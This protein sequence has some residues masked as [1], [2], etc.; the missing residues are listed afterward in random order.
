MPPW[1]AATGELEAVPDADEPF[2]PPPFNPNPTPFI[3]NQ[4]SAGDTDYPADG[5]NLDAITTDPEGLDLPAAHYSDP[6]DQDAKEQDQPGDAPVPSTPRSLSSNEAPT[7]PANA[8]TPF[9]RTGATAHQ[10][11][12]HPNAFHPADTDTTRAHFTKPGETEPADTDPDI[13]RQHIPQAAASTQADPPGPGTVPGNTDHTHASHAN[14]D[15]ADANRSD[16]NHSDVNATRP[17]LPRPDVTQGDATHSDTAATHEGDESSPTAAHPTQGSSGPVGN[18]SKPAQAGTE[19][20]EGGAQQ[21]DDT[22]DQPTAAHPRPATLPH[23]GSAPHTDPHPD[24]APQTQSTTGSDNKQQPTNQENPDTP[25]AESTDH[26][27][28][29]GPGGEVEA[30][31]TATSPNQPHDPARPPEPG[32][33]P[34]WPP[35]PATGDKLPELPFS[36][37]T[38]GQKPTSAF[39]VPAQ[40]GPG[41]PAFPP[42]AF[43]QPP[44][45]TPPPPPPPPKSKRALL[46]TLG[47]LA[48]AGIATGGFFA[49]Q[50]VTS[51]APTTAA[52]RASAPPPSA[53]ANAATP[54][55][56]TPA[57]T[58]VLD[59]EQTD[60]QKLSLS[61]AFPK[62]KVSAAGTT[63]TR[64]KAGM[65][66]TCAKAATG[67]F[68]DA[69]K[70]RECSRVLRATYVDGKRR[71]AVTTG[72][73]VLP[74]KD[75]A[76]AADQAKDLPNN[77]WFR[78]LPGPEKSG[79][80]RVHI[81][82]GYAAGLVWGRYIVF[83][84]ATHADGHTPKA[85]EKTLP[86]VSAEFRDLTSEVLERRAT[87]D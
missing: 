71:Y 62:R 38:W 64:V 19:P 23:A 28:S 29:A 7:R 33:V 40:T 47:A 2:L 74:D 55:P 17:A 60:P 41:A 26:T 76:A 32:D 63:F 65:E 49:Y 22:T 48:L 61:E 66:T 79:G 75:A 45:Q 43:K 87:K 50:T 24:R 81:A 56:E 68:A 9:A 73:A 78:P 35:T 11:D 77:V 10:G 8:Q 57:A 34:V 54:P 36:R 30:A 6:A 27:D 13:I 86:K 15:L 37:D 58:S 44:F 82:G 12:T 67:A 4:V 16:V 20:A 80:E 85:D 21:S 14:A 18:G 72:I 70:E 5:T 1:P 3:L 39:N 59:S 69:L 46:V 51:P 84:Y 25:Q 42:G 53:T 83:S 31:A 52:T